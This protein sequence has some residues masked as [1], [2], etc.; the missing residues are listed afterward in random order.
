MMRL[1]G[2]VKLRCDLGSGWSDGGAAGLPG[3]LWPS[4]L[5]LLYLFGLDATLSRRRQPGVGLQ[6]RHRLL[7][8]GQSFLLVAG[9]IRHLVAALVLAESL[10]LFAIR[11]LGGRQHASDLGF[12][13]RLA[14]LHALIT[15][16]FM[17][18]RVR[19]DLRA[20]KRDMAEF[21]QPC[22]LAQL[23]NL[24]EQ[25]AERLQMPL[26]EVAD[27]AKVRRIERHNHHKIVPFAAGLRDPTRRIQPTRIA[28]Q[29]KR[30]HHPRV[31][32]RLPKTTHIAARDLLE[33]K[34]LSH[35]LNDKPR[36]MAFRHEVL[37]IRRQQQCLI[38]IPGAKILAHSSSLNQTRSKLNSDYSDRLLGGLN[39]PLKIVLP[40]PS[41][42]VLAT[43]DFSKTS[44]IA[45]GAIWGRNYGVVKPAVRPRA[46]LP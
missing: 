43:D 19:F 2:S 26:A 5:A 21:D 17:F 40:T 38:D 18:R 1:S 32:R 29:Q 23:Q 25:R 16:R 9:P 41:E 44:P 30:H 35:Q 22:R 28:V 15:H 39:C 27:R 33:I 4:G 31:K 3:F 46:A 37:H 6:R 14:F 45:H 24:H 11:R 42:W 36:D 13:F 20:I 34:A 10:V 12:Q 7:D 8:L